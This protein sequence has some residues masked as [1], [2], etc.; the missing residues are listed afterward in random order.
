MDN[1]APGSIM[2]GVHLH[3]SSKCTMELDTAAC[4]SM[5]SYSRY[6][7]ILDRCKRKGTTPP[8]L[9]ENTIIMRQA[10]G[11]ISDSV[12]GSINLHKEEQICQKEKVYLSFWWLTG[13]TIY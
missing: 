3:K 9:E 8:K 12:K 7:E 10:D 6:Q 13:Q 5:L 2:A 4:K 11:T 1:S